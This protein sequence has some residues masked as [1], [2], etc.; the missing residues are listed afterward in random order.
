MSENNS[1]RFHY[2][3]LHDQGSFFPSKLSNCRKKKKKR[4]TY[5]EAHF[6][7]VFI[8]LE[9]HRA[10]LCLQSHQYKS[11]L[12]HRLQ[13][14]SS[15]F[16]PVWLTA[17][18]ALLPPTAMALLVIAAK[19]DLI[20]LHSSLYLAFQ[21]LI[22]LLIKEINIWFCAIP[23]FG[24]GARHIISHTRLRLKLLQTCFVS[25]ISAKTSTGRNR[26]IFVLDL[27]VSLGAQKFGTV[28]SAL[29]LAAAQLRWTGESRGDSSWSMSTTRRPKLPWISS[30]Q[31][32]L[33]HGCI[34]T[35][36]RKG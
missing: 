22:S 20:S 24:T 16:I 30:A 32:R 3:F 7:L 25:W 23:S 2:L 8:I 11:K 4:I 27:I 33:C 1:F 13:K 12:I 6:W 15:W 29:E 5:L 10:K 19:W 21:L 34:S 36:L 35:G 31:G 26:L 17:R 14:A 28:S 9:P 18:C